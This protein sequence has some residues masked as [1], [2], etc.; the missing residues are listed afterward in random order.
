MATTLPLTT[1]AATTRELEL[2]HRDVARRYPTAVLEAS[3]HSAITLPDRQIRLSTSPRLTAR[4]FPL[5]GVRP[6][7][8]FH[9]PTAL[10]TVH[11]HTPCYSTHPP[12]AEPAVAVACEADPERVLHTIDELAQQPPTCHPGPPPDWTSEAPARTGCA[13]ANTRTVTGARETIL[14]YLPDGVVSGES[15]KTFGSPQDAATT[16]VAY[17]DPDDHASVSVGAEVAT[18]D[19]ATYLTVSTGVLI[20]HFDSR[21]DA[22]VTN[23]FTG[24]SVELRDHLNPLA[25]LDPVARRIGALARLNR[26]ELLDATASLA[27]WASPGSER[28]LLRHYQPTYDPH[29]LFTLPDKP[30]CAPQ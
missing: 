30:A 20:S 19:H 26:S 8:C 28:L 11:R 22:P 13:I 17:L 6:E 21:R 24:V 23:A 18:T 27:L 12:S 3:G 4:E 16:W 14:A 25:Q 29:T 15:L 10:L 5:L 9:E 1:A 2:L 7:V